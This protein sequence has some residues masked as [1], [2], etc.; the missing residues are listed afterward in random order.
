MILSR[1]TTRIV[2]V[3]TQQKEK[4]QFSREK[5]LVLNEFHP[6]EQGQR[7]EC[8]I[9]SF[10]CQTGLKNIYWKITLPPSENMYVGQV[11]L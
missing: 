5:R 4:S 6:Q 10:D 7:K 3:L 8:T 9:F 11:S 2:D 1:Q